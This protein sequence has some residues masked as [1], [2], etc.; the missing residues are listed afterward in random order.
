[1]RAMAEQA[2]VPKTTLDSW[3][4]PPPEAVQEAEK[5]STTMAGET[6]RMM[7][8]SRVTNADLATARGMVPNL[9]NRAEANTWIIDNIIAPQAQRDIARSQYLQG[10]DEAWTSPKALAKVRSQ[11]DRDNPIENFVVSTAPAA[12]AGAA[13]PGAALPEGL[14]QGAR[15]I[16]TSGGKPVYQAPDGKRY[17]VQ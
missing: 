15:Q 9:K 11:W 5:L 17:L 14:P 8:P 2:G 7:F 3:K 1:L 10:H 13:A 6:A 12:A 4:L 16:G